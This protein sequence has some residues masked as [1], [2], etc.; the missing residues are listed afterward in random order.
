MFESQ[1]AA[2]VIEIAPLDG[3]PVKRLLFAPSAT[4]H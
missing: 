4:P 2:V 1:A 3:G